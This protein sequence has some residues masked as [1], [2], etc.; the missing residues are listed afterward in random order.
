VSQLLDEGIT[1]FSSV[2][3]YVDIIPPLMNFVIII[4]NIMDEIYTLPPRVIRV[5]MAVAVFFMWFKLLYFLRIFKDTG[6]L[7]RMI[8]EVVADMRFFLLILFVSQIAFGNAI[9]MISMA[10]SPDKQFI[11]SWVE[12]F[13]FSYLIALGDWDTSQFG[14]KALV[15]V[16]VLFFLNTLFSTVVMLNLLISIIGDTYGKVKENSESAAY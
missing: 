11:G 9:Y 16:W 10:N 4:S 15:A 3:N 14:E 7:I 1:Y 5:I 13:L 8:I 2:W 6:Y 12:S